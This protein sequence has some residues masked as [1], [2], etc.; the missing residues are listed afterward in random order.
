MI[1]EAPACGRFSISGEGVSI[2]PVTGA[3][4][5]DAHAEGMFTVTKPNGRQEK[6]VDQ[7]SITVR[8]GLTDLK[9]LRALLSPAR[10][11]DEPI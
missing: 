7:I 8:E 3:I 5:F 10:R 9:S 1:S 2:D 4:S 11:C 6:P